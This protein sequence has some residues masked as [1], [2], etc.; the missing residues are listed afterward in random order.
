MKRMPGV[1]PVSGHLFQNSDS[2]PEPRTVPR[3]MARSE[4]KP[5]A[6]LNPPAD[7]VLT[8]FTE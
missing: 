8:P 1:S 5:S 2:Q 6:F 3:L 4:N 7:V